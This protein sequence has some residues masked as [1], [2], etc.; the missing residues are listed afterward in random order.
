[1]SQNNLHHRLKPHTR[2]ASCTSVT[3]MVLFR[4]LLN[5]IESNRNMKCP[6]KNHCIVI[7]NLIASPKKLMY[8]AWTV[9]IH[10]KVMPHITTH[11]RMSLNVA[12]YFATRYFMIFYQMQLKVLQQ[13]DFL[14]VMWTKKDCHFPAFC[15]WK[16]R[17][18][19]LVC[20]CAV[21]TIQE[22]V[23]LRFSQQRWVPDNNCGCCCCNRLE[24]YP[25]LQGRMHLLQRYFL[26]NI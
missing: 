5:L 22:K 9:E 24:N 4:Q 21:P 20:E 2:A 3:I 13:R 17:N 19:A 7:C 6:S 10:M 26:R 14:W 23:A 1:M 8:E 11:E 25:T 15:A 16:S 12:S 18:F